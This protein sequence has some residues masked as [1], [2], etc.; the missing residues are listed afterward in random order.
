MSRVADHLYYAQL[1][2]GARYLASLAAS[3]AERDRHLGM[4]GKYARLRADAGSGGRS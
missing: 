1:E 4:A 2:T 3:S